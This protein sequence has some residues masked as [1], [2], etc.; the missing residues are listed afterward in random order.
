MLSQVTGVLQLVG[1]AFIL[2]GDG[3]WEALPFGGEPDWWKVRAMLADL[4]AALGPRRKYS[5]E[6]SWLSN[7]FF[8]H[9]HF[10]CMQHVK[11]QKM[12]VFMMLFLANSLA[13]SQL[14]TGAFEIYYN[15][16]I[17]FSKL[18]V[19]R[20]PSGREVLNAINEIR[21]R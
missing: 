1:M 2:F 10:C 3:I 7:F 5:L 19:G 8:F 20:M 18:A 16:E 21:S 12:Q 17:V 4:S 13:N 6:G 15:D 9:C 11:D 14:S